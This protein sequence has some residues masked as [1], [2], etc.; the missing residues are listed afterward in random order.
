M[1]WINSGVSSGHE[2]YAQASGVGFPASGE[3]LPGRAK[4]SQE[5]III[6]TFS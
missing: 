2:K 6:V 3:R 4:A 5:I 1:R